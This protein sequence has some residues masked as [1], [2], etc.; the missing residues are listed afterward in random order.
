M[1]RANKTSPETQMIIAKMISPSKV[2]VF[3][4][5]PKALYIKDKIQPLDTEDN[6]IISK[7]FRCYKPKIAETPPEAIEKLL[8]E[9]S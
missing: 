5:W 8:R 4:F 2:L 9:I 3:K 7:S 1:R 6:E